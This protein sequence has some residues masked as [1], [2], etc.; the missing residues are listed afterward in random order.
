MMRVKEL[1]DRVAQEDVSVLISGEESGTGNELVARA[2]QQKNGR[3]EKALVAMNCTALSEH[4]VENELFGHENGAFKG[5][6]LQKKG[7]FELAYN[8]TIFF[9]NSM[10]TRAKTSAALKAMFANGCCTINSRETCGSYRILLNEP[11]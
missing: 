3:S 10:N 4:L 5:A 1:I 6:C 7:K 8:S 2:F 11:S 9:T